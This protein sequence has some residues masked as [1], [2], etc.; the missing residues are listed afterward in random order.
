M[1]V[2][3]EKKEGRRQMEYK[4]R[5]WKKRRGDEADPTGL[6]KLQISMDLRVGE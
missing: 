4:S 5:R 2:L 1:E 6:K 3:E